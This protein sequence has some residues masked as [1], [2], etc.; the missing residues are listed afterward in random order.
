MRLRSIFSQRRLFRFLSPNLNEQFRRRYQEPGISFIVWGCGLTALVFGAFYILDV[1][2]NVLPWLGGVQSLRLFIVAFLLTIV[3]IANT[4]YREHLTR[5]YTLFANVLLGGMLQLAAWVA[6][7]ARKDSSYL[8]LYSA[9]TSSIS[10]GVVVACGVSRLTA[11]N[12]GLLCFAVSAAAVFYAT[13]IDIHSAQL[14]RMVLHLTLVNVVANYMRYKVQTRERQLFLLAKRETKYKIY[15]KE[16]RAAK[17]A[18][19]AANNAKSQFLANMSHEVRTP[20]NGVIQIL[21]EVARTARPDDKEMIDKGRAA[22]QSLLKVLDGI[23]TYAALS[24]GKAKVER[25]AVDLTEMCRTAVSL[26]EPAAATNSVTLHLRLDLAP[27]SSRVLVDEVKLFQILTNLLSN[28]VKFTKGGM[29]QL[30]VHLTSSDSDPFPE[31]VLCIDVRDTGIGIA[32]EHHADIFKPFYQVQGGAN[33]AVG[34]TGLGL[35]IVKDLIAVMGGTVKMASAENLGTSFKV[36]LPVKMVC[37]AVEQPLPDLSEAVVEKPSDQTNV[38]L[39]PWRTSVSPL[40]SEVLL[41]EDN[42]FNA[43]IAMRMLSRMGLEVQ[44]ARNGLEAVSACRTQEF[45]LILMDCQM[46]LCDGYEASRAIR[47]HER[48][49]G[50]HNVPIIALTANNL[51]G[52][53]QKCLSAGMSAYL[54]KPVSEQQLSDALTKWLGARHRRIS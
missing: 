29:V 32:K 13:R 7:A 16:L 37:Q 42:E 20:M 3:V 18:A 52:D 48:Q 49:T 40:G 43:V 26:L 35:A 34:G 28:A 11:L 15:N 39:G 19:E 6:Y 9:L 2:S 31:A 24:Q 53:E 36:A 23:L 5:N 46:P 51:P 45:A 12:T 30:S 54:A 47:A 50:R 10:T 33:R 17:D 38:V 14:A 1:S 44:H 41:V 4:S 8:E 22:G 21:D 25:G 27:E